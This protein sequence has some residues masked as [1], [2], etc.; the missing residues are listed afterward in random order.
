MMLLVIYFME[1]GASF[2]DQISSAPTNI[3]GIQ[4]MTIIL[5]RYKLIK[6]I[7]DLY[8]IITY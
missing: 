6:L 7:P 8:T 4:A 3:Q 5:N 2:Y 1:V